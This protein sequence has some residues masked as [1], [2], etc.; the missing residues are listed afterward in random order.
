MKQYPHSLY[1]KQVSE[2]TQDRYGN[3]SP[4]TESWVFH[5]VCREQPSGRE[6]VINGQDGKAIVFSS[7]IHMPTSANKIKTNTEVLVTENDD[8]GA[9]RIQGQALKFDVGQLHNR[10]WV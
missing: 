10:L 2:S 5:S 8:Q 3:W 1:V 4:A 7:V 9:V 6:N